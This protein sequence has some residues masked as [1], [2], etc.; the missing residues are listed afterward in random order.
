MKKS[1]FIADQPA[2]APHLPRRNYVLAYLPT[3][4]STYLSAF[5]AAYLPSNLLSFLPTYLSSIKQSLSLYLVCPGF[6]VR[7]EVQG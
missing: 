2:P 5:L 4:L 7:F 6:R 1:L 3:H